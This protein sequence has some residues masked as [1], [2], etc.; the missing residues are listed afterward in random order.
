M[1]EPDGQRPPGA[2]GLTVTDG[3]PPLKV[4][5]MDDFPS[6]SACPRLGSFRRG[7]M[8]R[9]PAGEA[10]TLE[11]VETSR[12]AAWAGPAW[13]AATPTCIGL[14]MSS[15]TAACARVWS[16]VINAVVPCAP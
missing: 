10:W 1:P 9:P 12:A 7:T 11:G 14:C 15:G 2:L 8:G 6:T 3:E 5:A 4:E 16:C 13:D